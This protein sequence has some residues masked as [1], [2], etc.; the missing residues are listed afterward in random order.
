MSFLKRLE[1]SIFFS[2][3][4]CFAYVWNT[5]KMKFLT[6]CSIA[7]GCALE[8]QK[9]INSI[10][11]ESTKQRRGCRV[12]T[13]VKAIV[14][15]FLS[16][17][18]GLSNSFATPWTVAHRGSSVHGISQT[19]IL[20]WVVISFSRGSSQPRNWTQVSCTSRQILYHRASKEA[21]VKAFKHIP[22][23]KELLCWL[24]IILTESSAQSFTHLMTERIFHRQT[25]GSKY[26]KPCFS[27]PNLWCQAP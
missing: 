7:K 24:V 19:R 8:P 1:F 20:E 21:P 9:P 2:R 17:R 16:H 26:Y 3:V 10:L 14:L 6:V 22:D 15:L 25:P 11:H 18:V 5:Q 27:S 13:P 12:S 23:R 4:N